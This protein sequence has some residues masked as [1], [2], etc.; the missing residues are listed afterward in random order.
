[1]DKKVYYKDDDLLYNSVLLLQIQDEFK[2]KFNNVLKGLTQV[3]IELQNPSN[4]LRTPKSG[5]IKR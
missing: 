2:T 5:Y 3:K 4:F 1:M